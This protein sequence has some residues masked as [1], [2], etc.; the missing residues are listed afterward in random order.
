MTTNK[1]V[2]SFAQQVQDHPIYKRIRRPKFP[3]GDL[4]VYPGVASSVYDQPGNVAGL[5]ARHARGDFGDR[6]AIGDLEYARN[7]TAVADELDIVSRFTTPIGSRTLVVHTE[8]DR[9][10]TTVHVEPY[11][12]PI[13]PEGENAPSAT[14]DGLPERLTLGRAEEETWHCL[15]GNDV[16]QDGFADADKDAEDDPD[17]YVTGDTLV[18]WRCGRVFD[19]E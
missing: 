9:S 16:D 7:R 18:C 1:Q 8:A 3:L 15:C 5:L 4:V 17:R 11:Q 13:D 6:W 14:R 19:R 2:P 12:C 10:R